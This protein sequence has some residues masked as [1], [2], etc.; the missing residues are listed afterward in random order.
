MPD[1]QV[2][3]D[4]IRLEAAWGTENE[5]TRESIAASLPIDGRANQWGD[6][7]YLTTE[8]HPSPDSTKT[9]VEPGDL[10]YWPDGPAICL[11][12]GP[13][14]AST[15]DMPAAASPVGVV[16]HVDDITLLDEW[17]GPGMLRISSADSD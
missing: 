16:G 12:W 7:L 9:V 13:T 1:L 2:A 4:D 14:P 11:F 17:D 15:T 10:A 8:S 5:A 6:E 3:V